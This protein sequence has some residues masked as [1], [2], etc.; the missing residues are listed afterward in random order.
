MVVSRAK[1][2]VVPRLAAV[3]MAVAT[4]FHRLYTPFEQAFGAIL[5]KVLRRPGLVLVAIGALVA[6]AATTS[7]SLGKSLLPE[8]HQGR[9][10][11]DIQ[12]PVG[13]PLSESIMISAPIENALE[14]LDST[15]Y[16]YA[17]IGADHG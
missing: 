15:D 7:Q 12:L 14:Q 6:G 10:S 2:L 13:T 4:G 5:P 9:L 17:I 1:S 3:L 16:V 11:L 8:L